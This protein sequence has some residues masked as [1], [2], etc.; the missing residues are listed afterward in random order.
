MVMAYPRTAK[1]KFSVKH[2]PG[3]PD[4]EGNAEGFAMTIPVTGTRFLIGI[5]LPNEA[6]HGPS[7]IIFYTSFYEANG[8]NS[9]IETGLSFS[10]D[11]T[12]KLNFIA[13]GHD[14]TQI[15]HFKIAEDVDGQYFELDVT[16]GSSQIISKLAH[17]TLTRNYANQKI[18]K[19]HLVVAAA[20]RR[21]AYFSNATMTLLKVDGGSH[22]SPGYVE[23]VNSEH[24][25]EADRRFVIEASFGNGMRCSLPRSVRL[26]SGPDDALGKW[27]PSAA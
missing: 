27:M 18:G 23:W 16:F 13:V 12:K 8:A 10:G 3:K 26:E 24:V 4:P 1:H 22:V 6:A 17:H 21:G 15:D 19:V 2:A 7:Y 9:I 5:Q 25:T 14:K 11:N 20:D